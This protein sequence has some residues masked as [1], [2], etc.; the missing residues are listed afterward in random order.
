MPNSDPE[1]MKG[2]WKSGEV[3]AKIG[4]LMRK[5]WDQLSRFEDAKGKYP[6][7]LAQQLSEEYPGYNVAVF[8]NQ[9]SEYYFVN[10]A[11]SHHECEGGLF[12]TTFG[13]E[14]WVFECG[15][16]RRY[17]DAG[18]ENWTCKGWLC[19]PGSEE[20]VLF[21]NG[22]EDPQTFWDHGMTHGRPNLDF[23]KKHCNEMTTKYSSGGWWDSHEYGSY[24]KA[25]GS[26][27]PI[28]PPKED[29]P[30][31]INPDDLDLENH[32]HKHPWDTGRIAALPP[33]KI[34]PQE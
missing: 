29:P 17:G 34:I 3:G 20:H 16:L 5:L 19:S 28:V 9:Y 4:E 27:P 22:T 2:A 15:Y 32:P 18:W 12:G 26:L 21:T 10:G 33:Q 25:E 6:R 8:H 11:H 31:P 1:A 13:Y 30:A 14:A 23:I 24:S 7:Q